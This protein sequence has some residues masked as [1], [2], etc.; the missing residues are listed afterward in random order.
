MNNIDYVSDIIIATKHNDIDF[1]NDIIVPQ[2]L[3]I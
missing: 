3:I 1:E 2:K